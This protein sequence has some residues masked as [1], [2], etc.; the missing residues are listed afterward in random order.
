MTSKRKNLE[1]NFMR[2]FIIF[3][4]TFF[5]ILSDQ[6]NQKFDLNDLNLFPKKV[7]LKPKIKT[8]DTRCPI[9]K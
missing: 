1:S 9:Q 5:E 2:Y 8:K 4:Y 3:D 6:D 7:L